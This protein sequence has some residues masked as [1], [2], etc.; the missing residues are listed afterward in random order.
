L[1]NNISGING[2]DNC[3]LDFTSGQASVSFDS[4]RI[5]SKQLV[6]KISGFG[7][8]AESLDDTVSEK[9]KDIK[10][11]GIGVKSY[12]L[13]AAILFLA[14]EIGSAVI[15]HS[16]RM[17]IVFALL[18][19]VSGGVYIFRAAYYSIRNF[20]ADM[21]LLMTIAV[22]GAVFLGEWTEAAVTIVLF[23]IA[24]YIEGRSVRRAHNAFKSLTEKIPRE[25]EC[26]TSEG[27]K[28]VDLDQLR[29]D[30]IIH[31]KPGMTCPT[32]CEI[33]EGRAYVNTSAV[34][35]ESVPMSMG[36]SDNVLG[37]SINTDGFL[38]L[39]VV[40]PFADS[41]LTKI[42]HM[43]E[44]A[45][46]RK[47]TLASLVD[48]FARVYTPI[49]VG[50]AILVAAIPPLVF[51]ASFET[52][53][54]RALVFLVISCP[55]ALVISTPV[56]VICSL[57]RAAR[58]GI[59]IKGGIFL[60]KLAALKGVLFDKTG[61]LT[62]GA[63]RVTDIVSLDGFSEDEII[64]M[65]A[66]IE[67]NS[68]HPIGGAILRFADEKS[69]DLPE[70]EDFQAFPGEGAKARIDGLDFMLGSHRFFHNKN[71][72]NNVLHPKV[73]KL[74]S[75]GQTM[76]LLSR[77]EELVGAIALS[78]QV[79][80]HTE[81]AI[82]GIYQ[83]GVE[84]VVMLTGDNRQT[85][86]TI[87]TQIGI[88]KVESGLLPAD[89]SRMVREY[90]TLLGAVA[91]VGDGINDAPAL[92]SADVGIAMGTG[93]SDIAIEVADVAIIGDNLMMVPRVMRLSRK[94]LGIIKFNIIFALA[95]KFAFM[96]LAT[97]GAATLWM[98]VLA[99]MGTSL[100]VIFNALRLLRE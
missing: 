29:P 6:G 96:I 5:D 63:F 89:K 60:E 11:P 35:G 50:L 70:S 23:S 56:A 30:D 80:A 27:V 58:D 72:C 78:D 74:E 14:I 48:R 73:H 45:A 1:E 100:L 10:K 4:S 21:N 71:I 75:M 81:E 67:K 69:L 54:Y 44:E 64:R 57:T 15:W 98:A 41:T 20:S 93:G 94:A 42:I 68:E 49:V 90:K 24:N 31:L 97:M 92:A 26:E 18:A 36:E 65:A 9:S 62:E 47:A 86:E 55:C 82:V 91:M 32:D 33:I 85:A 99:D 17:Q 12:L 8:K 51:S 66:A 84:D 16:E 22:F 52:W 88:T 76:V 83:G 79:K 46:G 3:R 28:T 19:I 61:T 95:T 43:V 39:K 53:F 34:T 59:L 38:R 13:I 77:D 25:I 2:V 7:H 37:G 87:A 40:K